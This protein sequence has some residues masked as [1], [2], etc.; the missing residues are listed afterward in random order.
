MS[1][2]S[3][4]VQRVQAAISELVC[5]QGFELWHVEHLPGPK[6]LRLFIDL[7]PAADVPAQASRADAVADAGPAAL[8]AMPA[9]AGGPARRGVSLDDCARIS[10]LVSDVLDG[11][12]VMDEGSKA[13]AYTLEVSSP[14]LDRPLARPAHFMRFVGAQLSL[15][16]R[17]RL[18]GL[19][20]R[21]I[22]GALLAADA[23][24]CTIGLADGPRQLRY[25]DIERAQLVPQF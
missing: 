17:G 21:K 23:D 2:P 8:V 6:V 7:P 18:E 5:A 14:G 22:A 16:T 11:E 19:N 12:G 4:M 3:P 24:G 9:D 13:G 15:R 25:D 20:T 1:T 10:R